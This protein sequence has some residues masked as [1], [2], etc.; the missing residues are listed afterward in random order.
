MQDK[1]ITKSTF[2]QFLRLIYSENLQKELFAYGVDRYV[3]KLTYYIG[4][5][6]P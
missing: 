5:Q 3:N 6:I 1:N 4:R 2:Y